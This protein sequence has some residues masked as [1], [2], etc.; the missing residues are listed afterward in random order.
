[1]VGVVLL[2]VWL[3]VRCREIVPVVKG[4]KEEERCHQ[5]VSHSTFHV[6]LLHVLGTGAIGRQPHGI[7]LYE[8]HSVLESVLRARALGRVEGRMEG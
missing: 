3:V 6:L 4:C 1:M 2:V 5:S 8:L 7:Y